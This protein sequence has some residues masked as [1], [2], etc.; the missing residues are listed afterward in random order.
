MKKWLGRIFLAVMA[1]AVALPLFI[2]LAFRLAN[3]T[4]GKLVVFGKTRTYLLYVPE[5]Y[6]PSVPAP[7]VISIH[8]YAE[9]PAHQMEISRWN[10]LADQ[11][12]FLVVYPSGTRFP[13]RWRTR[14]E[15]GSAADPMPDVTFIA[16]LIDTLERD[17]NIDPKRIY[18][19][20]LS[21]GGGMSFV[22][23]CELSQRIAAVGLVAGAYLTP[24]EA[25][26]P[27]RPVPAILFHGTADPI[28]PYQGGPSRSFDLPF[29]VIPE[30][31]NALARHRGCNST[32][33][34]LQPL[35]RVRGV[36][37]TGCS[38]DVVFYTIE[39][40]G[41][42]WPGGKAIPRWIAGTTTYDIDATRMMWDFFQQHPLPD[43]G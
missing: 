26:N 4:N 42:T 10:E 30:W 33:R 39:G 29:P 14:A 31:V 15:V 6:H 1:A 40:G 32:P 9:W 35:G 12:G 25:C 19:N 24:W 22:L 16:E 38:A 11:Y 3:R 5:R 18:A 43:E 34:E 8:G 28:V 7:L 23:S 20:G 27:S 17:Y 13:L 36:Q 37:Y 2:A 21:N 41:H